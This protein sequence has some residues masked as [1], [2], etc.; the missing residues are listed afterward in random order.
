MMTA[1]I[2]L[3]CFGYCCIACEH[4]IKINKTATA[5]LTGI[6]CW[7]VYIAGSPDKKEIYHQVVEHTGDFSGILFFLMGAM[8]IVELISS[9]DGFKVITDAITTR[10]KRTLLWIICIVAFF[11][12]A[13]LDNLTTTIVMVSLASKLLHEKNDRML[14]AGMIVIA[15]NA[16]GAWTPIGDVTTT[17]LWIGGNISSAAIVYRTFIPSLLCIVVPLIICTFSVHGTVA[18][19]AT[20]DSSSL[21]PRIKRNIVFFS[22]I[23]MLLFVPVF[24][25][26]THLPPYMGILF[27]VGILWVIVELLHRDETDEARQ[28][29][30]VT[31]ALRKIDLPSV[32]FFLGILVAISALESSGILINFA[33][34]VDQRIHDRNL[35]VFLTGIIS[36]IIDNVPLVAAFMG[37][38]DLTQFPMDHNFWIFLAYCAG[39][40]GSLLVIG[41]AAGVVAMGLAK[42]EFFWYVRKISFLAFSGYLIGAL[43]YIGLERIGG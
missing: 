32:L 5:L 19:N 20:P 24:K 9:H 37:M 15:A 6:V 12:S 22:G 13:V 10:K 3:F 2:I 41:S 36:S 39:T 26:L 42:L 1:I 38:Y 25:A 29:F 11:L 40:G 23:G 17:M 27:G 16:G 34:V 35:V 14:F 30:S 33:T 31:S 8:T 4:W 21:V 28:A 7:T 18:I 43:C